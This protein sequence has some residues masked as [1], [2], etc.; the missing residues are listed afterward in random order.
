MMWTVGMMIFVM[1]W[2][3]PLWMMAVTSFKTDQ[4]ALTNPFALPR[5][6]SIDAYRHAWNA[7]DYSDLLWNSMLYSFAGTTLAILLALVP[8]FALSRFEIKSRVAIFVL[9]LTP[10]M[11]PQ[12]TVIIPLFNLF[13]SL[14]LLDSRF[15]LIL[16]HAAFGMPLEM[17]VLTGFISNIPK[18]LEYAARI[19]GCTDA[20]VLRYIVI[21]LSLPAIAVGFILNVI[22]IWKEYFFSLIFLSTDKIMPVTLGI[23]RV[24]NDRYFRSVNQPAAAVILAQLPIVLLFILAYRWITEGI[25]MG[26]VKS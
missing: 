7:L 19:D 20:D 10:I 16:L 17:L 2:T 21:P 14:N 11:L 26:S 13:R 1:V 8:A 5:V 12:Q 6:W 18:E 15:G 4:E 23:V 22:D 9:L 25:Y 3:L 24:T